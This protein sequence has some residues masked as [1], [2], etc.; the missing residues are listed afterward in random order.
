MESVFGTLF[1]VILLH[2][3]VTI[4]MIGGCADSG[5]RDLI[6]LLRR[7]RRSRKQQ[8]QR[9]RKQGWNYEIPR[10]HLR[11]DG[12]ICHTDKYHYQAWKQ[13]A[14]KLG[15]CFDETINN[16]SARSQP[17]GKA[18]RLYSKRY[19]GT[20]SEEEKERYTTEKE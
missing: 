11:S 17:H 14:D 5:G 3:H 2:E 19:D 16:R 20:M 8:N 10:N 6:Q 15:I 13:V 7:R 4:R 18:S 9:K 1:S 12:V